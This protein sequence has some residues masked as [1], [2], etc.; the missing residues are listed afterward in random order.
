MIKKFM[1]L[2]KL[3]DNTCTSRGGLSLTIVNTENCGKRIKLSPALLKALNS[4]SHVEVYLKEDKTGIYIIPSENGQALRSGILYNAAL[5]ERIT[6]EFNL[7][8]EDITSR[9]FN[10][11]AI[12][13]EENEKYAEVTIPMYE[14]PSNSQAIASQLANTVIPEEAC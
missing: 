3:T 6:A 13:E 9:S 1:N 11:V 12:K 14:N 10:T 5:V 4:P 2:D 7:E 8:Y